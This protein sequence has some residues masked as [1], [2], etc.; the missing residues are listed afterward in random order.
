MMVL[1]YSLNTLEEAILERAKIYTLYTIANNTLGK[2][3]KISNTIETDIT[4]E[5]NGYKLKVLI[6]NDFEK[7]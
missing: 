2:D 3:F 7:N 5:N 4:K 6:Q 1:I